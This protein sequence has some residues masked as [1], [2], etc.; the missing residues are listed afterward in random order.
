MG[1][2]SSIMK[3]VNFASRMAGNMASAATQDIKAGM[4]GEYRNPST[5]MAQRMTGT[6]LKQAN[7]I[8]PP[9]T[10]KNQGSA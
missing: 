9:K 3:G 1:L 2:G 8:K 10:D 5:N 6:M 7:D 4:K